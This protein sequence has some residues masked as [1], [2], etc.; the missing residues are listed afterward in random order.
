MKALRPWVLATFFL[1]LG[2][3]IRSREMKASTAASTDAQ[4]V[5]LSYVQGDVRFNRGDSQQPDLKKPW[6]Q[7]QA[8]LPIEQNFA[9]ATGTD[10]RAEIEF[11]S[12]S[13]MY[14][15]ENSVVL[16]EHLTM[17]DGAPTTSLELV[18]GT[19]T[20]GLECIPHELFA[21][22]TPIGQLQIKYPESS[23]VRIDSYLNGMALTPQSETGWD[24]GV[25]DGSKIHILRGQTVTYE[26]GLPTQLAGPSKVLN[27][28]DRWADARYQAR[29]IAMQAALKASGLTSP[30]P[31]LTDLYENGTFS[32]CAPYGTCWEPSQQSMDP[33]HLD[34]SVRPSGQA[35]AQTA[36]QTSGTP[37]APQP[38]KFRTLLS[39][40]PFPV[41]FNKSVVATTPQQLDQL[42]RQ[43]YLSDL[44]QPWSW[45]VCHYASWIYRRN[46]YRVVIRGRRHHHP[47]H[48][49][50]VGKQTGFVPA[51]PHDKAGQ[52]PVNLK[53]GFF[54]VSPRGNGEKIERVDFRPNEEF[55]SL[56]SPP[57]EFRPG[58]SPKLAGTGPPDIRGRLVEDAAPGGKFTEVKTRE[59]KI[60]Y[61]YKTGNFVRPE[62]PSG[63]HSNR[64][65][66]VGGVNSRGSFSGGADR[67]SGGSRSNSSGGSSEGRSGGGSS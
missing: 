39:Q 20:I 22:D 65:V 16:F 12:G 44:Q 62:A 58:A 56:S 38:V 53:H 15:A 45:P 42:T 13:I 18:S 6:E 36:S 23:F 37:F 60:T 54:I 50:K 29:T 47:V 40:C 8:N 14:V 31:G 4:L 66:I 34:E 5:R 61:D 28:W 55:K 3:A 57:K 52:P 1:T 51:H 43:A 67:S 41:W 11:E 33:S 10:G 59:S 26:D 9:L 63:E 2:I 27:D 46:G 30:I 35:A 49:V 25:S 7:A 17:K 64:S 48:W 19:V 24:L 32:P 21:I